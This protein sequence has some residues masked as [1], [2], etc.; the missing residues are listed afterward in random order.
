MGLRNIKR[1]A[2]LHWRERTQNEEAVGHHPLGRGGGGSQL[3][4][5]GDRPWSP[6]LAPSDPQSGVVAVMWWD[7]GCPLFGSSDLKCNHGWGI[8]HGIS[9]SHLHEWLAP[10][11]ENCIAITRLGPPGG[12]RTWGG[13]TTGMAHVDPMVPTLDSVNVPSWKCSRPARDCQCVPGTP[14]EPRIDRWGPQLSQSQTGWGTA[15]LLRQA[16]G[17]K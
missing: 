17:M 15:C 1:S 4:G 14:G 12:C 9:G 13:N 7:H 11:T 3:W 10:Q 8:P 16:P 2:V 5:G 6:T